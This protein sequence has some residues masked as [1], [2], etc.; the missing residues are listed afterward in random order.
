VTNCG[1]QPD[2]QESAPRAGGGRRSMYDCM[3]HT[4]KYDMLA[5]LSAHH[6]ARSF[7]HCNLHLTRLQQSTIQ[8]DAGLQIQSNSTATYLSLL[9]ECESK[10]E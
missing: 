6:H 2:I 10:H 4:N 9:L 3:V 7:A 5:L 1:A 8:C